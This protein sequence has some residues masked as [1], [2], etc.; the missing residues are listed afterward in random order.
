MDDLVAQ[1]LLEAL[2]PDQITIAVAA[3]DRMKTA[4]TPAIRVV[5]TAPM[6]GM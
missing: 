4:S 1:L 5:A 2:A 3:V 6:P